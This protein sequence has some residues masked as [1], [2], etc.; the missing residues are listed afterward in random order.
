MKHVYVLRHGPKDKF[1]NLTEKGRK[2]IRSLAGRFGTFNL[3]LSSEIPRAKD[4]AKLLTNIDS[5]PDVRANIITITQAE[6]EELFELGKTHPFGIAGAI[7][8]N[9]KYREMAKAQGEK[10]V[11]MI[12]EVLTRLADGEK[13]LIISHD[14]PMAAA[15][16]LLKGLPLEK[17]D[18][19]Y[20]PL[21]GFVV[22]DAFE[23]THVN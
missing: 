3:I 1:G 8:D 2:Q 20:Q 22:N 18:H 5:H 14:A 16:R 7:F 9:E 12:K 6:E 11:E 17:I 15:E 4:T 19:N 10:L 21:Q 13:A 23:I